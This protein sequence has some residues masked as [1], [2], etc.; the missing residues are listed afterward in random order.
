MHRYSQSN[1]SDQQEAKILFQM[2]ELALSESANLISSLGQIPVRFNID[3]IGLHNKTGLDSLFNP[4]ES[5][6]LAVC[7][8]VEGAHPGNIVFLLEEK[9]GH[10]LTKKILND[11]HQL[12][13]MS[14]MEEEALTEIGNIIVNNFLSHYVQVL[15]KTINTLIPTL[16]RGH[17]VQL[18]D[19]LSSDS[20]HND[21]YL[22]KFSVE[23]SSNNVNAY[24]IWFDHLC[25]WETKLAETSNIKG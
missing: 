20:E 12:T 11:G 15:H 21:F 8:S 24:I 17:Y 16:K 2:T 23:I 3:S 7:H 6:M 10:N 25:Q 13:D 18:V 5:D 14:E 4:D 1:I 9:Q 22:V 19:E